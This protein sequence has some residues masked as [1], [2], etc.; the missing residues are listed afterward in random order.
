MRLN[1][2][3]KLPPKAGHGEGN[4]L[5]SGYLLGEKY[6]LGRAATVDVEHGDGR[7]FLLGFRPR[8]RGQTLGAFMVPFNAML[9]R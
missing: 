9:Q 5:R 6:L 3:V 7:V 1:W 2:S 8:G 4:W